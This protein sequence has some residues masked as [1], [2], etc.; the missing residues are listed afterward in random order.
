MSFHD[1]G[2]T[3]TQ[4]FSLINCGIPKDMISC[5][6][7]AGRVVWARYRD[8]KDEKKHIGSFAAARTNTRIANFEVRDQHGNDFELIKFSTETPFTPA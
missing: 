6:L 4:R 3:H 7:I 2:A 1:C 5:C 8:T